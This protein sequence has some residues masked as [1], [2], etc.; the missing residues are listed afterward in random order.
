MR[1]FKLRTFTQRQTFTG[2]RAPN[3]TL[4]AVT[5]LFVRLFAHGIGVVTSGGTGLDFIP[6]LVFGT[7]VLFGTIVL[8]DTPSV[9]PVPEESL[10]AVTAGKCCR[11]VFIAFVG[12]DYR[13]ITRG[14]AGNAIIAVMFVL[15]TALSCNSMKKL[16]FISK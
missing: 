11:I 2:L 13:F 12:I 15:R 10:I 4:F 5:P 14:S 3:V 1:D 16:I 8:S 7:V 6:F 9:R